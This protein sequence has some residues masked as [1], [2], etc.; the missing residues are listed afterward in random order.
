MGFPG[1]SDSKETSCNA[2]DLGS[3]P[4]SG[5]SP[6]ERNGSLLQYSGL[7]NSVDRGT[8]WATVHRVGRKKSDTTEWLTH[9]SLCIICMSWFQYCHWIWCYPAVTISAQRRATSNGDLSHA[10]SPASSAFSR[11]PKRNHPHPR[12][13]SPL[14]SSCS[15]QL[16]VFCV[17]PLESMTYPCLSCPECSD[18]VS[19]PSSRNTL[20]DQSPLIVQ[21][22]LSLGI[23]YLLP[24][25]SWFGSFKSLCCSLIPGV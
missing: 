20:Q 2:G 16:S 7:E 1:G 13:Y 12:S 8:W 3:I 14:V 6:G 17:R 21:N 23:L 15:V 5:R 18:M 25:L 10:M 22:P 11:P 24:S 19:A 9:T 4:G